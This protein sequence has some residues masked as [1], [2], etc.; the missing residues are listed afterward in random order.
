MGFL[1]SSERK[2]APPEDPSP[3]EQPRPS[4]AE[5]DN[6]TFETMAMMAKTLRDVG[7][8]EEAV[9]VERQIE[10]LKK[11]LRRLS[12]DQ[13]FSTIQSAP[14]DE[15]ADVSSTPALT[16]LGLAEDRDTEAK[17]AEAQ[18]SVDDTSA[19][20]AEEP[21][22]PSV[23]DT[24]APAEEPATD[25]T[26]DPAPVRTDEPGSAEEW[27]APEEE[28]LEQQADASTIEQER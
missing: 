14:A 15:P 28:E 27:E 2:P 5:S 3:P 6:E 21:A 20:P 9:Q 25:E 16:E 23:D 26:G 24:S 7:A 13:P 22:Q 18:Q 8:T 19:A 4:P 17:P 1:F 11:S 12:E 10:S